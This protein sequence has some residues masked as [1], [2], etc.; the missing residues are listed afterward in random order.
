MTDSAIELPPDQHPPSEEIPQIEQHEEMVAEPPP[1]AAQGENAPPLS[2]STKFL[3]GPLRYDVDTSSPQLEA[4]RAF[5]VFVRVTNP[6]ESP[7]TLLGVSASLPT[8]FRDKENQDAG[9][10]A[11]MKN[12]FKQELK[13]RVVVAQNVVA[14]V[15]SNDPQPDATEPSGEIV[16]QHGN[17]SLKRFT[18]KTWKSTLFMPAAYIM[19]FQVQYKIDGVGNQDTIRQEFNIRAPLGAVLR[20]AFWGAITGS[21]LHTLYKFLYLAPGAASQQHPYLQ[22]LGE[23]F[24]G[25]LLGGV[26]VVAFARKKDTQPFISIEDFYG[27][28]FVGFSAGYVGKVLLDKVLPQ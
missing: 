19:Q 14:S 23:T 24:A 17:S 11:T 13:E 8:E 18:L 28:L 26:L 27:G 15:A 10:W 22:F 20:G 12:Q 21:V 6:Y 7:V 9:L 3:R 1:P 5:S 2:T 25:I 4:G 16:L